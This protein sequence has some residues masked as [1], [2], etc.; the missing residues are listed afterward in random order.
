MGMSVNGALEGLGLN[1]KEQACYLALLELGEASI[2]DI[3]KKAAI[4]RPTAYVVVN[5]LSEKGFISEFRRGKHARFIAK[6]P[7]GLVADARMRLKELENVMPML[8]SLKQ[9]ENSRPRVLIFEGKEGADRAFDDWFI[10][11]GEA[12]FIS[13]VD[14]NMPIF[15]KTFQRITYKMIGPDFRFRELI[16]DTDKGREYARQFRS[17]YRPI[18]LLQP[19]SSPFAMDLGVYGRRSVITSVTNETVSVCIDSESVADSFRN[20]FEGLWSSARE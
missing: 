3:A 20:I 8:E 17:Q 18:R 5:Q 10:T 12:L 9:K 4:K 11:K 7:S 19:H 13:N 16:E 14:L 15:T 1:S 6:E 2:A